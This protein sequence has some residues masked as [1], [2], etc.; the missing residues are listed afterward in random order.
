MRIEGANWERWIFPLMRSAAGRSLRRFVPRPHL[1]RTMELILRRTTDIYSSPY[2]RVVRHA[3]RTARLPPSPA[4]FLS[5]HLK[6]LMHFYLEMADLVDLSAEAIKK[7]LADCLEVHVEALRTAAE[8]G[9]GVLVPTV[10]LSVPFRMLFANLPGRHSYYLLLHSRIPEIQ[11]ILN[12]ADQGWNFLFLEQAPARKLIRAF[13]AGGLVVCN[14][15]HVYPQTEVTL[16]PVLGH[17]AIVPSGIFRIARRLGVPV[18]PLLMEENSARARLHATEVL[19]WPGGTDEQLP[20]AQMLA[21]V[22]TVLNAAIERVPEQWIGWGNLPYR[23]T[24]WQS[25]STVEKRVVA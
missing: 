7:R 6:F 23:W 13:E 9:R 25:E 21:R 15:D 4:S 11:L 3:S 10:Q 19:E 12:K 8:G 18:V 24:A 2:F 20:V 22:H 14:I 16:A 17:P 5:D 1:I